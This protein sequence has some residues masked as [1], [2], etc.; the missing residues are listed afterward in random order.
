[1][2]LLVAAFVVLEFYFI[3]RPDTRGLSWSV[4]VEGAF[5]NARNG[6][7]CPAAGLLLGAVGAVDQLSW[8]VAMGLLPKLPSMP[9]RALAWV[10]FLAWTGFG[11]F[12]FTRCMLGVIALLD[13]FGAGEAGADDK[14]SRAF[15]YTI[16]VLAIPYLYATIKL[17]EWEPSCRRCPRHSRGSWKTR[18]RRTNSPRPRSIAGASEDVQSGANRSVLGGGSAH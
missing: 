11:A 7:V 14:L 10:V 5:E 12:L 16:L 15:L 18:A 3:E 1:M 17:A 9:A 2:V 4:V 6:A 8:H 13:R